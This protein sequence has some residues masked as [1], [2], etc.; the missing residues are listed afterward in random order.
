MARTALATYTAALMVLV[1]IVLARPAAAL[2]MPKPPT[3]WSFYVSP[4]DSAARAQYL[5]CR[6]A[7]FDNSRN[8]GSFVILDFGSQRSNGEGTYLPSSAVYWT[9]AADENYALHFAYGYQLCDPLHL[10]ILS[11]GTSNDGAV[12][13]G[14]LGASWGAVVQ[15]TAR[16]ASNRGYSNVA[17][18]G[19]IDAEPGFGSFPHFRGW[20]WGDKSGRGYVSRTTA[21]LNDF[22]SADGCPQ[23]LGRYA[24]LRCGD[25]WTVADE[26]SAVWGWAPNEATPEIYFDGCGDYGNQIGQWANVSAFGKHHGRKGMVRFVGPLDQGTGTCLTPAASWREFQR[27]LTRDQVPDA[28]D[29]STEIVTR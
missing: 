15:R 10:L 5:G 26:Y 16:Q 20:E 1:S 29:F 11:I 3:D 19:A 21:L 12:T 6:Q 17:V 14:A 24:N 18:Q 2:V 4:G 8:Y 23:R 7:K 27:G 25:G 22:G 9:N 28:M 13:D